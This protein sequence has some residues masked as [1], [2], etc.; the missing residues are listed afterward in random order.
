MADK[1]DSSDVPENADV[2]E[3]SDTPPVEDP[4]APDRRDDVETDEPVAEGDD[5][6]EATTEPAPDLTEDPDTVTA[7]DTVTDEPESAEQTDTFAEAEDEEPVENPHTDAEDRMGTPA[8]ETEWTYPSEAI[9][10]EKPAGGSPVMLILGG[11]LAAVVGF[12]A[13]F[14][15]GMVTVSGPDMAV[16]S[17]LDRHQSLIDDLA[18]RIETDAGPDLAPLEQSLADNTATLDDLTTRMAALETR[19]SDLDATVAAL[20]ADTGAGDGGALAENYRAEIE[21]LRQAMQAQRSDIEAMVEEAGQIKAAAAAETAKTEAR[22]ALVQ[23]SAALENGESFAEPLADLRNA[24]S[25]IPPALAENVDGVPTLAALRDMFPGAARQ[26]LAVSRGT[27]NSS[28]GDFFR[29]QLGVRS[30]EPREG[31][32]P[33]AILSR[34]EAALSGG[35]IATSLSEVDTLPEAARSEFSSWIAAARTR[36]ETVDAANGLMAELNSN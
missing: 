27:G 16:I 4:S 7:E 34:A 28:V 13:A 35:D 18:G 26:A 6:I 14:L 19:I 2:T 22:A 3:T 30:L 1:D 11:V 20:P 12:V 21:T 10:D 9:Y 32:D 33:D 29:T 17:R 24:G 15:S 5:T 8:K 23:I 25:Q 31:S 36:L